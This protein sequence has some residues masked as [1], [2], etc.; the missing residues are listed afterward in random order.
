MGRGGGVHGDYDLSKSEREIFSAAQ[1]R[2]ECQIRLIPRESEINS[3][4]REGSSPT[5]CFLKAEIVLR[6]ATL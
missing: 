4:P 5:L 6:N 1:V 2:Q 3:L